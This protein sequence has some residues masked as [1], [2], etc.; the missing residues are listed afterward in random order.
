MR[1]L[2]GVLLCVQAVGG[3]ISAALDGSKSWFAVRHVLPEA[4]QI[5]ASAVLLV[6]ALAV[7]WSTGERARRGR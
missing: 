6:I 7:L 4:A 2:L 5:P 1:E 3:G